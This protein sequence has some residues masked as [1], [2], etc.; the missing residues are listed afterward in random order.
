[1]GEHWDLIR[2]FCPD[3]PDNNAMAL[4]MKS[5]N[6]IVVNCP[7]LTALLE[8]LSTNFIMVD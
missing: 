5:Q 3:L 6:V 1:M 2:D 8:L 4:T 7:K